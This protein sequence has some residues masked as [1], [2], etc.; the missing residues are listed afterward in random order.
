MS[1][2]L[3]LLSGRGEKANGQHENSL[4]LINDVEFLP[5]GGGGEGVLP[6]VGYIGMCRGEWYGFQYRVAKFS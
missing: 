1:D 2:I 4:R 3:T 5:W 6:Y